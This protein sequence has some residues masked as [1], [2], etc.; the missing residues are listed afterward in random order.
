M[1]GLESRKQ[2][3]RSSSALHAA[4]ER[5]SSTEVEARSASAEV[6]RLRARITSLEAENAAGRRASR[7]ER[8]TENVR[9]RLLLDTLSL[10]AEGIRRELAL[11]PPTDLLPADTVPVA[12]PGPQAS[13]LAASRALSDDDPVLL[14]RLL[15][16]PKVHLIVDGYNV[17]KE[18]WPTAHLE[19]QRTTLVRGVA[20]VLAG[21]AIETTIVFDGA[22]LTATPPAVAA[23]RSVR[24]VF[25]P[26]DV[27]ADDVIRQLTA[28]E[29]PGR[30]VVVVSTD[31]EV[32]RSTSAMGA[33]S[34]ASSALIRALH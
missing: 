32:A 13:T 4:E 18:A 8:D 12:L 34:V 24:V 21:R 30:P 11:P 6:R 29:P 27:T 2:P 31:R 5:L 14:R 10:A 3:P 7:E 20:A 19:Q 28:A 26:P 1:L 16:L 25:S 15:E 22:A 17:S 9:L 33:R 23:A